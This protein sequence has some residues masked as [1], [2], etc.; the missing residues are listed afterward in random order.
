MAIKVLIVS[1]NPI[2]CEGLSAMLDREDDMEVVSEA[3][4]GVQALQKV[5][6]S[7]ID[8][9]LMDAT[10]SDMNGVEAT[11]HI[12]QTQPQVKLLALSIFDHSEY[13]LNM[14]RAGASG[15]LIKDFT[16]KEI[17]EAI[18]QVISHKA[19]LCSTA[20]QLLIKQYQQWSDPQ[21]DSR[22][23]AREKDVLK[24]LSNGKTNAKI[25]E[26]L[27]ISIKTVEAHRRS[28]ISKLKIKTVAELTR[29]AIRE[30]LVS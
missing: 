8:V 28:I 29:F 19:F 17:L 3:Y 2:L 6:K 12:K 1:S 15:C 14:L 26:I 25:A 16:I 4:S 13:A 30:G 9:V 11:S 23:T 5:R 22:L 18:R 20:T 7:N 24:L 27:G 10:L 21:K